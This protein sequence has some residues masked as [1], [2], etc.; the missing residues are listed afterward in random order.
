MAVL[1]DQVLL[2]AQGA[3]AAISCEAAQSD[4][5]NTWLNHLLAI[6]V[7]RMGLYPS[8][9]PLELMHW[10]ALLVLALMCMALSTFAKT[11]GYYSRLWLNLVK[12]QHQ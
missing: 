1:A 9:Q 4:V 7:W 12:Q 2:A 10:V 8:N 3:Q 5:Q 6:F 11:A